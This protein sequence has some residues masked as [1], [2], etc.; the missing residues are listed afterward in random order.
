MSARFKCDPC[1]FVTDRQRNLDRH[2]VSKQ[3]KTIVFLKSEETPLNVQE[4]C[5][6][7][8]KLDD[9]Q[10]RQWQDYYQQNFSTGHD[11][12]D[13]SNNTSSDESEEDVNN[14]SEDNY[15]TD[16]C[17][18]HPFTSKAE[19]LLYIFMNSSTHPVV[20]IFFYW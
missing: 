19:M 11:Y 20:S 10:C 8:A 13:G 5:G 14:S 16:S 2:L 9:L 3:H 15:G 6:E 7:G 18:W 1:D 4:E 12:N 17:E